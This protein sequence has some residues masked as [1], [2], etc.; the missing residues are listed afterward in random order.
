MVTGQ[1]WGAGSIPVSRSMDPC[2][3]QRQVIPTEAK[4]IL[5]QP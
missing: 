3:Q 5:K 1:G 4:V 2:T